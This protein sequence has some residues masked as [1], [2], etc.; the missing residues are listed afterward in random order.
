MP[1]HE[2]WMAW[3]ESG[4]EIFGTCSRRQYMA[5]V[6]SASGRVLG[7]GYNGVPS[8]LTHCRDGGC[9]RAGTSVT[10]GSDYGNCLAVHAEA[11]ALIHSDRS[12]REGGTLYVNGPP[13]WECSKLIAGSGISTVVHTE[14][15]AYADW[16]KCREL[17][18]SVGIHVVTLAANSD[19]P[20]DCSG[21]IRLRKELL[22]DLASGITDRIPLADCDN[23]NLS[24]GDDSLDSSDD[25]PYNP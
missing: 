25:D 12:A 8:G 23:K 6:L 10:H 9:P 13:C 3:C 16:S 7:T 18:E 4:A 24:V 17:L 19:N 20:G 1:S 5:I 14:D 21:P 11:N 15:P 2:Q 22:L